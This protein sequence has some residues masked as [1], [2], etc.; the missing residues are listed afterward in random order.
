MKFYHHCQKLLLSGCLIFFTHSFV[1][2]Q[3]F[4][5]G[6]VMD[7]ATGSGMA[8][9][10]VFL[11]NAT[12]GTSTITDGTFMLAN[13]RA[14]Q[15][16]LVVSMIGYEAFSTTLMINANNANISIHLSRKAVSLRP[17]IVLPDKI[18]QRY[19]EIFK[20]VF[21]GRFENAD[22]CKIVNPEILYFDFDKTTN[23]LSASTDDFL[24]IEN[25]GLGYRIKFLLRTF[26]HTSSIRDP[27]LSY[28][29]GQ[30][31][32]EELPGGPA[33]I[34]RWQKS[35]LEAY[36]GSNMHFFRSA[37]AGKLQMDGFVM[38]N[39]VRMP[40]KDRPSDDSIRANINR[41][42]NA[43]NAV[44]DLITDS[45]DFWQRKYDIP[46]TIQV[47]SGDTLAQSSVIKR[48]DQPGIF[49]LTFKNLLNVSYAKKKKWARQPGTSGTPYS[50]LNLQQAYAFFDSNGVLLDPRSL[51]LEGYWADYGTM[52]SMLPNDYQAN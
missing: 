10:T 16:E 42:K 51:I 26:T 6:R 41:L 38:H 47:L 12:K 27:S 18:R 9:A 8:G 45:I 20:R 13:I 3:Y 48:T 21:I 31:L 40:N 1:A 33:K 29:E 24:V 23:T 36:A 22:R 52:A 4:L 49:A 37:A 2:A 11:S 17:V 44:T 25:K 50:I 43:R 15:Y 14:G 28:Y 7:S 5:S 46:K 35:R 30:A 34:K 19:Y 32:F 39:L